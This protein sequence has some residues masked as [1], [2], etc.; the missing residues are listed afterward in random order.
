MQQLSGESEKILREGSVRVRV[1]RTGMLQQI[2]LNVKK[3]AIGD[4]QF[5]ELFFPR[6]IDRSE[7]SR[8]ANELGLPVEAENGTAFPEGKGAK[9]FIL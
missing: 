8:I 1:W 6:V 2:T 5:V 7:L 4:T 3:V 9:D